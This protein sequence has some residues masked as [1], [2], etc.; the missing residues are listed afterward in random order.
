M[1][2]LPASFVSSVREG[3]SLRVGRSVQRLLLLVL[4]V[5]GHAF[6]QPALAADDFLEPEK[7]F[8]FSAPPLDAK[9]I[10][11]PTST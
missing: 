11:F 2:A 7:A 10:S 1:Q 9:T 3:S 6:W 4:V 5:F 8:Q